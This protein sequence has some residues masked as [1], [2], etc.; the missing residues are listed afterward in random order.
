MADPK[1]L[2]GTSGYSFRDWVGPYYPQGIKSGDMLPFY[3]EEFDT[4]EVNYTYYRMP[5]E[6]TT[7]GMV[8]KTPE[9]FRFFVKAHKSA[10]HERDL[11][12]TGEF[13]AALAPMRSEGRLSG[14]LFQFPQSF[15]NT[16]EN[17][18]YLKAVSEAFGDD[19]PLAVEFRDRSWDSEAV[20]S[21]LEE[22]GLNFVAVDEP[23]VS[24]LFPRVARATGGVGYLRLHSRDGGKWYK[25][26]AARYDYLYS[27]A[28]LREWLPGLR[29]MAAKAR[30][31]FVY[32]NNCHA[33][34]AVRNARRMK[35]LLSQTRLW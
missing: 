22:T 14:V 9:G 8:R 6:K 13:L 7:A 19:I 34:Q 35:E 26:G 25:G 18:K 30:T 27:E 16:A 31:L 3:A 20:Y 4:V 24:T 10:T 12:G 32:F 5:T 23:E 1:V 2:V 15:K 17:R 21:Y 33:A 28:E 11:A 29:E